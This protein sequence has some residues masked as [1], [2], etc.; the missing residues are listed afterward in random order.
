MLI[1]SPPLSFPLS[2]SPS[3]PPCL[4][5]SLAPSPS[6]LYPSS[7]LSA[8]ERGGG[9]GRIWSGGINRLRR[10][11]F[12]GLISNQILFK[13]LPPR[14]PRLSLYYESGSSIFPSPLWVPFQSCHPRAYRWS[15]TK[16]LDRWPTLFTLVIYLNGAFWTCAVHSLPNC[17]W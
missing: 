17:L 5:P 12:T 9:R 15:E 1:F 11:V 10:L 7:V 14:F 2:L 16:P 8:R 3:L 13:F 6:L 4:L